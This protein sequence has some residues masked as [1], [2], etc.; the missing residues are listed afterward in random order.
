MEESAVDLLRRW[1]RQQVEF[2]YPDPI[3]TRGGAAEAEPAAGKGGLDAVREELGDC[4]RCPLHERR[5]HLVFGDGDPRA[6]I[7]FVGEAPGADEDRIGRPFVGRS[8]QLLDKIFAAAGIRRDEVYI[9]NVVKCRPPGNRDPEAEEIVTCL[10]FLMRQ[11][12]CVRP[13]LICCL[14]RF[15]AQTLLQRP[16]P[17]GRLRGRWHD[18]EGMRLLCTY[19]PSACL[20]NPQYKR[21]VWEDFQML[22]DAYREIRPARPAE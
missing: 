2:G 15:A 20:R 19:H 3:V 4:A 5:T 13:E 21:P 18:W 8:G 11:I 10:P 7:L 9:T 12:E 14:G 16:D 17:L 1:A 6:G 22:R